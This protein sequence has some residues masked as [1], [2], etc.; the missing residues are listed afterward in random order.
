[1]ELVTGFLGCFNY[2]FN[3]TL[4]IT[5]SD[6]QLGH[7]HSQTM[8]HG[9]SLCLSGSAKRTCLAASRLG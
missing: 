3:I 9:S 5:H 2:L 8:R 1:M 7:Y 4:N 6:I